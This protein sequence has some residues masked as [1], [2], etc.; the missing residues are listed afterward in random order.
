MYSSAAPNGIYG[1]IDSAGIVTQDYG[2]VTINGMNIV[3]ENAPDSVS[4]DSKRIAQAV[5]EDYQNDG[6]YIQVTDDVV[7][8]AIKSEFNINT[9]DH[10]DIVYESIKSECK[11]MPVVVLVNDHFRYTYGMTV[12]TGY[13]SA[14]E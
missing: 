14:T 8:L 10:A 6:L 5:P 4:E 1:K 2:Y 3:Y 11:G 7:Y 9:K 12:S 13:V